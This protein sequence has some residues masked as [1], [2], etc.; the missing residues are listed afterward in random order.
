MSMPA[1]EADRRI[2]A[3]LNVGT[4]VSIDVATG[5]A[6]VRLGDLETA[7]I[8]IMQMRSGTV[9]MT[10]MPSVGEQVTVAAPSGDL[11]RAFVMGSLPIDGNAVAP[12]A[13]APTMDLGGGTLRIIGDLFIDGS[14]QMTGGIVA[15]GDVVAGG[16]SLINHIHP[17]S[18]GTV[19]GPPQ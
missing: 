4:V 2:G 15:V 6:R 3:V 14:I 5:R 19:T 13:D 7:T 10:W 17:E 12:S 16:K 9:R 1:A 8:P 11:S 18:I